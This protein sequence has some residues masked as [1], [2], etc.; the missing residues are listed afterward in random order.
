LPKVRALCA[1]ILLLGM[2]RAGYAADA[3]KN[4]TYEP[5][6][7]PVTLEGNYS[8]KL[9]TDQRKPSDLGNSSTFTPYHED[10]VKPFFGLKLSKPLDSK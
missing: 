10:A 6:L 7:P 2:A 5:L 9:D 3:D 4:K 1:L 8:F